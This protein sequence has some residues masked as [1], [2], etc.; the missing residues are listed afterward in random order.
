V[1]TAR[2]ATIV[3]SAGKP[4][5][6]LL[7]VEPSKD[8]ALQKAVK[9]GRVMTVYQENVGTKADRGKVGFE[10]GANR[11]FLVFPKSLKRFAGAGVVGIKYDLLEEP[12]I[13]KSQRA[14]VRAPLKPK[15]P[16]AKPKH[17]RVENKPAAASKVVAFKPADDEEESEDVSEI[18]HQ[19]RHAMDLLE[20]GKQVA[21]FN[22]LKRIVG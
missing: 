20:Q 13:P 2:F 7:F 15:K 10:P 8:A 5:T 11:Q 9:A 18:K 21:A 6:H 19:V 17:E 22:L 3:Q 16:K 4:Q 14:I 12:T 1:K